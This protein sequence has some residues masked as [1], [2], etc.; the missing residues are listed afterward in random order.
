MIS[1]KFLFFFLI[2]TCGYFYGIYIYYNY[3]LKIHGPDSNIIRN[4]K[5][6]YKNKCYKLK[7]IVK[8]CK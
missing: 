7:P 1:I 3:F 8:L 2:T 6:N 5:F 4:I